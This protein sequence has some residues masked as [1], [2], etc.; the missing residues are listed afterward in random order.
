MSEAT[1]APKKIRFVGQDKAGFFADVRK[2]VDEY[3]RTNSI[4]KNANFAMV[5][6]T[7]FFLSSL[8]ILYV[9]IITQ[10]FNIY[11]TLGLAVLIGMVQAFIGF[12][13]SHDAIHGSY[14]SSRTVNKVLGLTFNFVGANDYVW[15]IYHN[16]IHHT[17]T[18]IPGH[19]EDIE[20]APGM[21]RLS[22]M[23]KR[24][25]AMRFQQYYAFLL[26]MLTSLS[27][28]FRKD[29]KKMF[30]KKGEASKLIVHPKIEFY[31]L[32]FFKFIYYGLFIVLP[33]IIMEIT[34]WQF[35][36]GFVAM[37]FGEGLVLGLV[38]QL[39]HVVK[40]VEFPEPN[41]EGNIEEAWAVHQMHTTANF[42]PNSPLATFLCGGLN[43]QVE[44]HL[45]PNICHIHYPEISKIVKK[46]AIEH[47]VPYHQNI[48][49]FGALR[50]HFDTLKQ[51]GRY[52]E[53]AVN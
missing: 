51:F 11:I 30:Q 46:T 4:G 53:I 27:W 28:V 10:Q 1:L 33:L 29:Y 50:S 8:V 31:R 36:I 48:T 5:M 37:H 26:Y 15:D 44:H 34:W 24:L 49:F 42:S 16:K 21:I 41:N 22:P 32:F 3:F 23:D 12:N 6:K 39:A 38:F 7:I 14:S 18:N 47:Q 17:Y 13:V 52:D 43:Y 35:I 19:D 25:P 40:G 2:Q 45:F 20:V 9:L